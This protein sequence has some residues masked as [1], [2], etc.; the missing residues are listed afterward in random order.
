MA[1]GSTKAKRLPSTPSRTAPKLRRDAVAVAAAPIDEERAKYFRII[2]EQ[3]QIRE[4]AARAPLP[5][6]LQDLSKL[7]EHVDEPPP[8]VA[9]DHS[10]TKQE[11]KEK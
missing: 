9:R 11:K 7:P 4:L 3:A 6:E 2:R 10:N 5:S 8:F 1:D